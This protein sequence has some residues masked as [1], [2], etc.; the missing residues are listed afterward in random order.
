MKPA[1]PIEDAYL[2]YAEQAKP[3]GTQSVTSATAT[4]TGSPAPQP[5]PGVQKPHW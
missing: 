2:E 5:K 1:S 4:P 3:Q